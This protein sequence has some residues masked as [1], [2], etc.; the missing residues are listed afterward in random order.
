[1]DLMHANSVRAGIVVALARRLGGPCAISSIR[2][3]LPAARVAILAQR[4]VGAGVDIAIANS[5][6]TAQKFLEA[7]PR[8]RIRT[9]FPPVNLTRF[10]PRL[11]S[12]LKASD[13][14]GIPAG[15][16]ILS[17]VAQITPW[18]GQ[19]EAIEILALVHKSYTD[20]RLLI[21]GEVKFSSAATRYNN[22][23]Y[24]DMIQGR[25][26]ELDLSSSVH[27]LGERPDIEEILACTDI[28]LAPS[29]EEPFGR[30]VIEGMA[31]EC[32]V[33]AAKP[34]GPA[35]IIEDGADG[36]LV[37]RT[38]RSRWAQLI[39]ELISAPQRRAAI[40]ARA[41][42]KV[43]DRFALETHVGCVLAIYQEVLGNGG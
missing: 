6:Y 29:Q 36:F 11:R 22:R 34:G 39:Y 17:I 43:E 25:V 20:A 24:M 12:A 42:R 28:V 33:L 13:L 1:V 26:H 27:F 18:K 8:A 21:V 15:K 30:S 19:L 40:G 23:A 38:D 10:D 4:L 9:V 5:G 7:A 35:E 14:L 37:D 2:D 41:R 3:V 32:T 31:M 16:P